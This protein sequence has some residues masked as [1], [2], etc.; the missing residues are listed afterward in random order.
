MNGNDWPEILKD[1]FPQFRY[2]KLIE[3]AEDRLRWERQINNYTKS[4]VSQSE[5]VCAIEHA[6]HNFSNTNPTPV[7]V[8]SWIK[9]YRRKERKRGE[10]AAQHKA[11]KAGLERMKNATPLERW[12]IIAEHDDCFVYRELERLGRKL[13]GGIDETVINQQAAEFSR[14]ASEIGRE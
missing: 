13:P 11:I 3:C 9:D 5:I 4:R 10:E 2:S 7:I 6:A 1:N 14:L 12:E 8:A